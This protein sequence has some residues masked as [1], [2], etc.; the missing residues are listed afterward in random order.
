M[1]EI[2]ANHPNK[3]ERTKVKGKKRSG[4]PAGTARAFREPLQQAV[5]AEVEGTIVDL[6]GNL[7]E[8]EKRFLDQQN[9]YE[10]G[11]YKALVQKIL[12]MVLDE[13][14]TTAVLK[15]HSRNKADFI[16]V[17]RINARLADISLHITRG[18]SGFNLLKTMEEIRGLVLDL[19]S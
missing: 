17:D 15:R 11:R 10:M 8:Q 14:Y 16:I 7:A 18:T 12:K 2:I 5:A 6:M 9:L 3:D 13:G 1:I 19:L 4:A